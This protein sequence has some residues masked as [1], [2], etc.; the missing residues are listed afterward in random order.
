VALVVRGIEQKVPLWRLDH[1]DLTLFV[2]EEAAPSSVMFATTVACELTRA[3]SGLQ[4]RMH[5]V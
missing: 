1:S 4:D 5:L 2:D 3:S